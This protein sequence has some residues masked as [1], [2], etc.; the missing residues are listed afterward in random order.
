MEG[1]VRPACGFSTLILFVLLF[2]SL[3]L[4]G[5]IG[6]MGFRNKARKAPIVGSCSL[7]ISAV[8]HPCSDETYLHL[9]RVQWGADA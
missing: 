7:A 4:L 8:C 3:L 1:D 9:A 6:F 2:T 5:I